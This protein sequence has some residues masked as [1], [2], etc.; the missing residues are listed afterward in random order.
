MIGCGAMFSALVIRKSLAKLHPNNPRKGLCLKIETNSLGQAPWNSVGTQ[1]PYARGIRIFHLH[2]RDTRAI[3]ESEPKLSA[4]KVT[5]VA[6]N[7][8]K[9]EAKVTPVRLLEG[10]RV[11]VQCTVNEDLEKG[12]KLKDAPYK[13]QTRIDGGARYIVRNLVYPFPAGLIE[14]FVTKKPPVE[15]TPAQLAQA[16][17]DWSKQIAD[18]VAAKGQVVTKNAEGQDVSGVVPIDVIPSV[19]AIFNKGFKLEIQGPVN[20]QMRKDQMITV[21]AKK[22]TRGSAAKNITSIG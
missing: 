22:G 10:A 7:T 13:V 1:T 2:R 17:A 6:D 14:D 8:E 18:L 19:P 12:Y 3:L 4:R 5:S 9:A 20:S 11:L 15:M 16:V 21:D